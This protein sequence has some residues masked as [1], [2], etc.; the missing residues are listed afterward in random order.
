MRSGL[1]PVAGGG[2]AVIVKQGL[3]FR[4]VAPLVGEMCSGRA[5][6]VG[7]CLFIRR[8]WKG[9]IF[10]FLIYSHGGW[11]GALGSR[12]NRTERQGAA[13]RDH[14]LGKGTASIDMLPETERSK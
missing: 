12:A 1:R 13:Q 8:Y 2:P 9:I 6:S 4:I 3:A 14:D 11:I 10:V 7:G 5:G